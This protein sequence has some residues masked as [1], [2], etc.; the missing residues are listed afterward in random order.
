MPEGTKVAVQDDIK[1]LDG[2]TVDLIEKARVRAKG[3][4]IL[5]IVSQRIIRSGFIPKS[6]DFYQNQPARI[7]RVLA[8]SKN[9]RRWQWLTGIASSLARVIRVRSAKVLGKRPALEVTFGN[10]AG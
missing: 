4:C 5:D 7:Q 6:A 10:L 8:E 9:E 2:I 1:D 3:S